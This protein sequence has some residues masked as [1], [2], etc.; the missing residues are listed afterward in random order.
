MTAKFEWI[1][2]FS[3]KNVVLLV[4][5]MATLA[6]LA[7]VGIS[8]YE[9]CMA[10]K[11]AF[12]KTENTISQNFVS[13]EQYGVKGFRVLFQPS[14]LFIFFRKSSDLVNIEANI[15]ASEIINVYVPKK[16]DN[17]YSRKGNYNDF[18]GTIFIFGTLL[19]LYFGFK[20]IRSYSHL[21]IFQSFNL[22]KTTLCRLV[23]LDVFFLALFAAIFLFSKWKGIHFSNSDIQVFS[24]F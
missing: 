10:K 6:Y 16:G 2:I 18:S 5:F 13:Y 15:D 4:I 24:L 8:E 22:A 23:I 11:K 9:E 7:I 3:R 21:K 12:T 1:R 19:M 14:P 20:S 17:I